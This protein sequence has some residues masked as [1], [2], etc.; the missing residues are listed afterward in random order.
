MTQNTGKKCSE[1]A[2]K[3]VQKLKIFYPGEGVPIPSHPPQ[4]RPFGTRRDPAPPWEKASCASAWR[5]DFYIF[6]KLIS[7]STTSKFSKKSILQSWLR[8]LISKKRQK[9]VDVAFV[10]DSY[11]L[12]YMN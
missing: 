11:L 8:K 5:L 7:K 9:F 2:S 3:K 4:T 10:N 12:H 1:N 6:G